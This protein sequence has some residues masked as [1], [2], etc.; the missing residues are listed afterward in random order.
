MRKSS[1]NISNSWLLTF[2]CYVEFKKG[3]TDIMVLK[4]GK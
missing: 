1:G 4:F 3:R 2:L